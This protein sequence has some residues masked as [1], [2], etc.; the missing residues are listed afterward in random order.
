MYYIAWCDY[1]GFDCMGGMKM[2]IAKD[3]N[4]AMSNYVYKLYNDQYI[5]KKYN[6][7]ITDMNI[8]NINNVI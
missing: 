4:Y 1:T 8:I 6:L 5:S 7:K 3:I 2:Y